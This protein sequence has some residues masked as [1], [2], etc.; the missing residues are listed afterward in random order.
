VARDLR[1]ASN[2]YQKAC[3]KNQGSACYNLGLMYRKGR[4]VPHDGARAARLFEKACDVGDTDACA[5]L[6]EDGHARLP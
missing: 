5:L 2:L 4:G 3:D 1:H 6:K